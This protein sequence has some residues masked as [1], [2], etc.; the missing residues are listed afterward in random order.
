MKLLAIN[1]NNKRLFLEVHYIFLIIFL[2]FIGYVFSSIFVITNSVVINITENNDF[3][4]QKLNIV[5]VDM[6]FQKCSEKWQSHTFW[7]A[8]IQISSYPVY[9]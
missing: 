1:F 8:E 2:F 6:L 9:T 5:Y 3:I 7:N 4:R